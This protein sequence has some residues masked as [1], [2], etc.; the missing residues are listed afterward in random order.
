[1]NGIPQQANGA[2]AHSST[3]PLPPVTGC[4]CAGQQY[5]RYADLRVYAAYRLLVRLCE[6]RD[7]HIVRN[8]IGPMSR[9]WRW[10]AARLRSTRGRRTF[11]VLGC[12][13]A[14]ARP[15]LGDVAVTAVEIADA[16]T[17]RRWLTNAANELQ[18][19]KGYL[20]DLD[21]AIGDADHGLNISR[22]ALL[23]L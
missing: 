7:I 3:C 23:P 9:R 2:N 20:T 19:A 5:G 14:H 12:A 17:I 6:R 1:M 22:W 13:R 21:A 10:Q 11:A 4:G 16:Q 18:A 15:A 8:L